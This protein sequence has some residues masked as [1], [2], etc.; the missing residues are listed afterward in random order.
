MCQQLLAASVTICADA[1]TE[2]QQVYVICLRHIAEVNKQILEIEKKTECPNQKNRW[3]FYKH[4][5]DYAAHVKPSGC[6]SLQA[7]QSKLIE[8]L[9]SPEISDL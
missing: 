6:F 4:K 2:A 5:S 9:K 1:E 8:D 3:L 7:A